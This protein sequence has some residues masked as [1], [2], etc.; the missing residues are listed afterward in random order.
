MFFNRKKNINPKNPCKILFIRLGAIGDVV[1]TTNTYRAI[2][3]SYPNAEIHY[4]TTKTQSC[5]LEE[6]CDLAK[7]WVVDKNDI[8][9][10][11]SG[12]I[13]ELLKSEKFD[14]AINFQPNIKTRLLVW[15][16]GIKKQLI[17]K[18]TFKLHAVE[19]FFQTA[20]SY[21]GEIQL[22][23]SMKLYLPQ[24][25]KIWAENEVKSYSQPLIALNAGGIKSPR[26]GRTYPIDKWVELGKK[27][28]LT[29]GTLIITGA[30][31]DETALLPL[32]ELPAAKF[33]VG[34]TT[35]EQNAALIGQC[36]LMISGDSGPL[37]IASALNVPSIGLY[38]SMPVERTGTYGEHCISIKSGMACV[39]CNR[40]KCKFLKGTNKIY[41]PCM[42]SIDI[43]EILNSVDKLLKN[44]KK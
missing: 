15:R 28:T 25:A 43:A 40:R 19:N 8:K 12:K 42:E 17:Y 44:L 35:I 9:I 38:G 24:A 14:A 5:L 20:K 10:S 26:Q 32:S 39:P 37:H 22:A 1:H 6:D 29:G 36:D 41:A 11:K 27:L 4:L 16:A 31:E 7:V 2:K 13:A 3:N 33:Y 21:F 30:K 18:K 23:E 34:K